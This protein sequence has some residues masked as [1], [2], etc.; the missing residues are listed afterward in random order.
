MGTLVIVAYRPKPGCAQAL[1]DL[2]SEHVP[3]L[4]GLGLVTARPAQAMLA[5]DGTVIEVFEWAEGGIEAAHR[6]PQVAQLWD[7]FSAVCDYL[8]L[9][10]LPEAAS[11]FAEFRP[12]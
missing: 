5:A 3:Y 12:L 7:R 4:R 1:I 10:Q 2:V 11:L 6:I 8:P 9:S